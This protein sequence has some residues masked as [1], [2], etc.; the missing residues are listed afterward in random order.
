MRWE[1]FFGGYESLWDV[2]EENAEYDERRELI[3]AERA[4]TT[5][6]QVVVQRSIEND[7]IAHTTNG[8]RPMHIDRI[9]ASWVDGRTCGMGART[10]VPIASIERIEQASACDCVRQTAQHFAYV[11][12]GAVL[13]ELER[14][15]ETVVVELMNG[16]CRGAILAVWKDAIDVGNTRF[17][18]TLS[19]NRLVRVTVERP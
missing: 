11:P 19:L 7:I 15:S 1:N 9:G 5:F 8:G 14:A 13:R 2:E 6:L 3:R 4:S 12:F 16:G 10:I 18:V 17:R